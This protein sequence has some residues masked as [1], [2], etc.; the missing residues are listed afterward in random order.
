LEL[1][2]LLV[3]HAF[4]LLARVYTADLSPERM[5]EFLVLN[6]NFLQPAARA[7]RR[8]SNRRLAPARRS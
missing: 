6:A 8:I 7:T 4:E 3:L 1:V 2:G 5:L